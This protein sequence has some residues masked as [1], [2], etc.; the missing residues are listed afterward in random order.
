MADQTTTIAALPAGYATM[1]GVIYAVAATSLTIWSHT[2]WVKMSRIFPQKK[3]ERDPFLQSKERR[4]KTHD[5]TTQ[6]SICHH[7]SKAI[8]TRMRQVGTRKSKHSIEDLIAVF[9]L[10][11]S[12]LRQQSQ[13]QQRTSDEESPETLATDTQVPPSLQSASFRS[14]LNSLNILVKVVDFNGHENEVPANLTV[15]KL[16][17]IVTEVVPKKP[18]PPILTGSVMESIMDHTQTGQFVTTVSIQAAAPFDL[19]VVEL[20]YKAIEIAFGCG[21]ILGSTGGAWLG[22]TLGSMFPQRIAAGIYASSYGQVLPREE[23]LGQHLCK[24]VWCPVGTMWAEGS[25]SYYIEPSAVLSDTWRTAVG[26]WMQYALLVVVQYFKL[27]LR[28]A[29]E[30][31]PYSITRDAIRYILLVV[32][33]FT[34]T[35]CGL[36]LRKQPQK[37]GSRGWRSVIAGMVYLVM[38]SGGLAC[39][40]LGQKGFMKPIWKFYLVSKIV[41]PIA[42]VGSVAVMN[43]DWQ[44][45]KSLLPETWALLWAMGACTVVW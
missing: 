23:M 8:T 2:A 13:V 43:V 41:D 16:R 10:I 18:S 11:Y 44:E 14:D 39:V 7:L 45:N 21:V 24:K 40:V 20:A 38:L 27:S 33:L 29:L 35:T 31:G 3:A 30:F 9:H 22:L 36:T 32:E 15:S 26:Y 37:L 1:A 19:L 12:H 28:R 42:A 4:S 25:T 6:A 34:I 17:E 5:T